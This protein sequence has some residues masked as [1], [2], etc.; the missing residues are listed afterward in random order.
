MVIVILLFRFYDDV[1]VSLLAEHQW[2]ELHLD[3]SRNSWLLL[4]HRLGLRS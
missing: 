2:D 4:I 3:E 1:I